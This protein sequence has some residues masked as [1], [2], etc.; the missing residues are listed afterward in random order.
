ML[1]RRLPR[2]P[3]QRQPK[4]RRL[5]AREAIRFYFDRLAIAFRLESKLGLLR[6]LLENARVYGVVPR[7]MLRGCVV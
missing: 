4:L 6:T 2:Y 7:N 1:K 5:F 3:A